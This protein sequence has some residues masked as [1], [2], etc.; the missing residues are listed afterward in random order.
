VTA[1]YP[2]SFKRKGLVR[3]GYPRDLIPYM[4]D[5]VNLVRQVRKHCDLP[6]LTPL[7]STDSANAAPPV[8][9]GM[10]RGML[11]IRPVKKK[12]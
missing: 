8:V 2:D 6:A 9:D 3:K 7:E 10:I 1:S 4:L 12:F 5:F 11:N